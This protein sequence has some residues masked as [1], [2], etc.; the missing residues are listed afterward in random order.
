ML[1]AAQRASASGQVTVSAGMPS[2]TTT[3]TGVSPAALLAHTDDAPAPAGQLHKGEV[4]WAGHRM[5]QLSRGKPEVE[6]PL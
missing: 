6:V 4:E 2:S 3:P 5:R 1:L